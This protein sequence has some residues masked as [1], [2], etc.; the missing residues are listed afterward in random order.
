MVTAA[1]IIF[2]WVARM[3]M[4]SYE[5]L[6]EKPF[7]EV[8]FHRHRA[9]RAGPQDEQVAGQQPRPDR[10][11]RQVR[12]RRAALLVWSCSRPRARTSSSANQ[13]LEVGRNFCNKIFQATKLVLGAWDD[14][15]L[16]AAQGDEPPAPRTFDL[17]E[18]G[19]ADAWPPNRRAASPTPGPASSAADRRWRSP[20]TTWPWRTA[21]S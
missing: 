5:F 16:P 1:D 4:A 8:L 9:R 18:V 12:R 21:G 17:S 6:D 10:P 20:T 15:G 14:A 2:F 19:D 13:T 3:V 11:D 7:S